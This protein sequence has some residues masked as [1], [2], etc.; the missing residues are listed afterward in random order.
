MPKRIDKLTPEQEAR[1]SS[2][3]QEWIEKGLT[4]VPADRALVVDGIERCYN[5]ANIPWHGN[6]VW[7]QSPLKAMLVSSVLEDLGTPRKIQNKVIKLQDEKELED[8]KGNIRWHYRFGGQFWSYWTAYI[9]FFLE[10]CDLELPDNLNECF[11]AYKDANSAGW[12]VPK[13]QFVVICDTPEAI[14]LEN[15]QT[16]QWG[17]IRLHNDEGPSIAFRDGWKL[18]HIH[19][20]EV[21]EQIVMAPDTLTKEQFSRE[22]NAEV[23]RVMAERIGHRQL[24]KLLG[25]REMQEDNYG[26]MWSA[27]PLTGMGVRECRW[28]EVV[29]GSPEPIGSDMEPLDEGWARR[30]EAMM[31]TPPLPGRRYRRYLIPMPAHLGTA[32]EAVA[33]HH[34]MT[35]ETYTL[36]RIQAS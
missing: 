2:W 32:H 27:A 26:V 33:W 10:V 36:D 22:Q 34:G 20:T 14:N 3:A 24:M 18:W 6:V 1:M 11:A 35:T 31:G 29:D 28:V 12:W 19:G 23:R 13:E 21:T 9:S 4:T 7:V 30:Y 15:D 17:S 8:L 16:G 5:Y 25:A